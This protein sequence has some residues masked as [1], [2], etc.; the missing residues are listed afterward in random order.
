MVEHIA[1]TTFAM[2]ACIVIM[3]LYVV[4]RYY[5]LYTCSHLFVECLVGA[6]RIC[7]AF[8]ARFCAILAVYAC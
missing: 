6:D 1:F 2:L 3:L 5:C 4:Y 7:F 8:G